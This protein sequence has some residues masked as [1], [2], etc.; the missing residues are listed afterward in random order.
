MA[1]VFLWYSFAFVCLYV[2]GAGGGGGIDV[3]V[4]S[5]GSVRLT[6]IEYGNKF[7]NN[8]VI[9]H[10]GQKCNNQSPEILRSEVL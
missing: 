4:H 6:E 1:V 2:C 10:N 5:G 8:S 9:T 7:Q 3:N